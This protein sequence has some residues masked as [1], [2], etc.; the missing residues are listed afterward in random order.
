MEE[1]IDRAARFFLRGLDAISILDA[2][3]KYLYAN[4]KWFELTKLD[5]VFKIDE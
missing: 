4:E 3:G 2:G 5:R 1:I